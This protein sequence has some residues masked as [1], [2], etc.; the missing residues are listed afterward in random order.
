[1]SNTQTRCD[2]ERDENEEKGEKDR[3]IERG[4]GEVYMFGVYKER[5][6]RRWVHTERD[7]ETE[8]MRK[9]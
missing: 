1:M 8:R 4:E 3:Q 9:R 2:A 5:K 7:R 6:E